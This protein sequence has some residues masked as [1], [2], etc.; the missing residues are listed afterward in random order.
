MADWG[1]GEED[2]EVDDCMSM[3]IKISVDIYC[4]ARYLGS[5][6]F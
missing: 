6:V 1:V 3:S 4:I 5:S 2:V